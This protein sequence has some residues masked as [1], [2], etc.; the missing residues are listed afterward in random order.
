M[1]VDAH[2]HW[3]VGSN[4]DPAAFLRV[5]DRF[6][7]D[8]AVVCGL[9]VFQKPGSAPMWNERLAGFC[10]RS[11][12]RLTPLATVYLAEGQ[13]AV[14]EARRSLESL[15]ARGFKFHPWLQGE[16]MFCE[17][18]YDLCRLGAEFGAPLLFHDG[19]PAY[20]LSSQVAVLAGMFPQTS[21]VLGHGGILHFWEE[22]LE[23][24]R[25]FENVFLVLCGQHPRAMQAVCDQAD[26]S[27]ILWGSDYVGPGAEEFIA[28][29]RGL[30]DGLT[31]SPEVRAGIL[32]DN[33]IKLFHLER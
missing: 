31:L 2:T 24:A 4:D 8:R 12:G 16:N 30:F 27:R 5:L 9:E 17:T 25:Q 29:R 20:S 7:T 11:G 22:A 23:T 21:F 32:G 6:G 33:S 28:Y 14:R 19:T 26:H 15:G 3:P 13:G 1:I 10:A 18:M